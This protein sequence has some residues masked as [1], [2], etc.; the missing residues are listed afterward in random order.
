MSTEK[1]KKPKGILIAI[2]GAID[3]GTAPDVEN[4]PNAEN[5]SAKFLE[6]GI[7]K[8]MIEELLGAT[9][10]IEIITTASMIPEETGQH[11]IDAFKRLGNDNIDV[12][13]IREK[14]DVKNQV[15]IDRIK[16]AEGV[17]M[18]GG[19][20]S[21]L[22]TI[23]GSSEILQIMH[24]RYENEHF[25][26]AGTSAGA[27]AMSSLMIL[28]GKSS[29]ALLKGTI[30]LTSGLCF[31]REVTFDSHFIKRGRIG[32]LFQT[33]AAYPT[34][35]GIGL[36]EDTGL[37]IKDGDHMEAIGSGLV[38]IVEGDKIQYTNIAE[39][40]DGEPISIENLTVHVLSKGHNYLL[41]GRKMI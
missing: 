16:R 40:K 22:T 26:L 8:R 13:H 35:L 33:I 19:D 30:K 24:D 6:I 37:L 41:S 28:G 5:F 10:R 39:I 14:E 2:G 17:L 31:I 18:T 15:Y 20:Q 25:V 38:V 32:R 7:L 27:M 23:F 4:T 36:G 29:E 1:S 12:I 21:R 11:Y 34:V 3:A 9:Q